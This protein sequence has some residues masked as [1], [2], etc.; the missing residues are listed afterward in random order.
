MSAFSSSMHG[1]LDPVVK[2]DQCA[3]YVDAIGFTANN[4]TDLIRN[5]RA[6]FQCICNVGLRLAIEECH[7]EARQFEFLGRN[8]S[9]EGVSPQPHK[10]QNFLKKI[11][12]LQIEIGFAALSGVGELLQ[13]NITRLAEKL[14]PF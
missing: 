13:R 1:Y 14:N 7:F 9:S 3:Q 4:A 5:I 6:V 2:A 11:E 10:I 8:I 12:I